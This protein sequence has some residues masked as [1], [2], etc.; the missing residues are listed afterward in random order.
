[1]P[2][3]P[4]PAP[5]NH[6]NGRR[7]IFHPPICHAE[8]EDFRC[9]RTTWNEVIL[10]SCTSDTEICVPGRFIGCGEELED[11]GLLIELSGELELRE[12]RILPRERRVIEFPVIHTGGFNQPAPNRRAAVVNIRLETRSQS[13]KRKWIGAGLV[14]TV[15]VLTL[16][17][18]VARASRAYKLLGERDR[19]RSILSK[20]AFLK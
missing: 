11:G 3:A 12:G 18:D 2:L 16:I 17:N 6:L 10:I 5:L 19:Y 15:V 7:I 13:G 14:L 20:L 4:Q 1:M 9:L 8:A